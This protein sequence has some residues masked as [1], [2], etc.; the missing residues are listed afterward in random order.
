VVD[1]KLRLRKLLPTSKKAWCCAGR[2]P[3]RKVVFATSLLRPFGQ[4][5][6]ESIRAALP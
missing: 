3:P 6:E 1:R 2:L 5:D 4:R